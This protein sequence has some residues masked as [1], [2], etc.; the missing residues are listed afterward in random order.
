M[1]ASRRAAAQLGVHI[2]QMAG[3]DGGRVDN[4][5]AYAIALAGGY[6]DNVDHGETFIYTGPGVHK[7]ASASASASASSSASS[8]EPEE[9]GA[10]DQEPA[11]AAMTEMSTASVKLART[12]S[13]P[14][15]TVTGANAHDR[16]RESL[17]VRVLRS[18][19]KA[20]WTSAAAASRRG[21][22]PSTPTATGTVP[23]TYLAPPS[24]PIR[25]APTHGVRYDGLYKVVRY[26]PDDGVS[27]TPVWQFE[28][29]RDDDEPAPWTAEGRAYCREHDLDTPLAAVASV[30][31]PRTAAD[32]NA[33]VRRSRRRGAVTGQQTAS[34]PN[35]GPVSVA[36]AAAAAASAPASASAV[37]IVEVLSD[38]E[39]CANLFI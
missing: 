28:L 38:S 20:S 14:L 15:N 6:E 30:D 9:R 31:S 22:A 2:Q 4:G 3:I 26:W 12:C 21:S 8:Q 11:A 7:T 17:P 10:S 33:N 13:A 25:F 5:G 39:D 32:E 16:W 18:N 1:F 37:E 35:S 36:A 34:H 23:A 29:R 27:G 19:G 24:H